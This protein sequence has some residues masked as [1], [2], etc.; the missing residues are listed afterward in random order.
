MSPIRFLYRSKEDW[1]KITKVV[2]FSGYSAADGRPQRRVLNHSGQAISIR[3]LTD[4]EFE[5][6]KAR[7]EGQIT[8]EMGVFTPYEGV[9]TQASRLKQSR[10]SAPSRSSG[11]GDTHYSVVGALLNRV[12][13]RVSRYDG[14]CY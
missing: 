1:N 2:E 8:I 12:R 13:V 14:L 10:S 4:N 7:T 5:K 11:R 9:H 3:T 6:W